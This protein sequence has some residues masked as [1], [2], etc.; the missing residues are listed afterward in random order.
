[1][2]DAIAPAI[3]EML[4]M[5]VME[6]QRG[7][8]RGGDAGDRHEEASAIVGAVG[9]RSICERYLTLK[10]VSGDSVQLQFFPRLESSRTWD[11]LRKDGLSGLTPDEAA[12]LDYVLGSVPGTERV[13][14]VTAKP[15]EASSSLQ[16]GGNL[17]YR[18]CIPVSE[19]LSSLRTVATQGLADSAAYLPRDSILVLPRIESRAEIPADV[20]GEWCLP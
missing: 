19:F 13:S 9:G 4:A 20:P 12:V 7:G 6:S 11:C 5:P 18:S 16:V 8:R 14:C 3:P 17:Y 2:L 15:R 1:M 10:K